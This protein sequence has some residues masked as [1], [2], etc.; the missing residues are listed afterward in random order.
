MSHFFV[1][2]NHVSNRNEGKAVF[3]FLVSEACAPLLGEAEQSSPVIDSGSMFTQLR[4]E[5]ECGL[6]PGQ[7]APPPARPCLLHF[8]AFRQSH[9][10]G[11]ALST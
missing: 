3:C 9:R 4:Q 2:V 11:T 8:T 10:Q 7:A 5:G 1:A 6:E